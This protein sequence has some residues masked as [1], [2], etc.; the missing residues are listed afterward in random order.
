M[1]ASL[2]PKARW[3]LLLPALALLCLFLSS[4][5]DIV[6]DGM[7]T[8]CSIN[9]DGTGLRNW[10]DRLYG[11]TY[12][13]NYYQRYGYP[14]YYSDDE[15]FYIGAK[16][17]RKGLGLAPLWLTPDSLVCSDQRWL[18]LKPDT[19]KLYFSAN[20]D[21]YECGFGGEALRNLTPD[22]TQ[23]LLRP[24]LSEDGR[25]LTAIRK[26]SYYG[27]YIGPI[28]RLDLQTLELSEVAV[29]PLADFAWY[30]SLQDKYYY[31]AL[32][33][34]YRMAEGDAA[35]QLLME[36]SGTDCVYAASHDRRWFALLANNNLQVYDCFTNEAT[37][38]GKCYSFAFLPQAKGIIVSKVV[39]QMSD[40]RLYDPETWDYSLIFDGIIGKDYMSWINWIDPR[41]DG[42]ALFFRGSISFRRDYNG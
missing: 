16:V 14:F 9:T 34:L 19:R 8:A 21:L 39:Y 20:G 4:C 29:T 28:V 40:L 10:D 15:V 23:T 6:Y 37:D 27:G 22:N 32:G 17:T 1:M 12:S 24:S 35:P 36:A 13:Y 3:R 5:D 26:V 41:W 33:R 42:N 7:S 2:S 31:H 25:Y 11:T 18:A 38:L 30:N